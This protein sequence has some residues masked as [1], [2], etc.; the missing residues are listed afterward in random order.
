MSIDHI[1]DLLSGDMD[2]D[3]LR[4]KQIFHYPDNCDIIFRDIVCNDFKACA[5]FLD[6][7]VNVAI[8]EDFIVR[9]LQ[10]APADTN[11]KSRI[12]YLTN[13]AIQTASV[14]TEKRFSKLAESIMSG[15]TVLFCE[16]SISA[17]SL[18]TR[19]FEAR[20]VN[21]ATNE[22]V[23]NGAQEGFVETLRTNITLIRRYCQ[24]PDLVTEMFSVGNET[25]LKVALTYLKGTADEN[26]LKEVRRRLHL[27]DRPAVHG[28]GQLQQLIED[29]PW[30]LLPQMLMT[31][32]PDRTSAALADGQFALLADCSPYALIAPC[33]IFSLMQSSDDAFSRWQYGTYMRLIR[34]I[35]MLLALLLPG[36]YVA[37]ISYHTQL[38]PLELLSSIAETRVNVPFPVLAE[39]FIMELSFFMINEA[40]LRIPSQ[41]GMSISI[42]GGLVLGQAAVQASII[43]PILIIVIA[44]SGLGCYC[45]PNY[46]MTISLIIYRL[47][48]EVSAAALGLFG[49]ILTTFAIVCQVCSMK[50]FGCDFVAPFAPFRPHN[51]DLLVRFP[52]R[53]QRRRMYFSEKSRK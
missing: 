40:N 35:G 44:L 3:L 6:G 12:D 9:A 36:L 48:I 15:G 25:Q 20:K 8:V 18:D 21:Q 30:A 34:F 23:V 13:K 53:Q 50:S 11:I 22:S 19:G 51:P 24:T 47:L 28:L 46:G 33:S 1:N 10:D 39:V 38:I 49:L 17:L 43:S 7:M 14:T 41:V 52:I 42:I 16:S 4:I 32:R 45:M 27:I 37:L 26:A 29:N 31:E 5:V 2:K